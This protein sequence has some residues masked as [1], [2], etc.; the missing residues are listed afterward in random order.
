M[1]KE[2]LPDLKNQTSI[3][4]SSIKAVLIQKAVLKILGLYSFVSRCGIMVTKA[5]SPGTR[6]VSGSNPL[7]LT[8]AFKNRCFVDNVLLL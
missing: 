1:K 2:I 7:R 8:L 5:L 4:S 6:T 3:L